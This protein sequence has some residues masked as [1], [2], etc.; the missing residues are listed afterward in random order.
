MP[1]RG[2]QPFIAR[3]AVRRGRYDPQSVP[4]SASNEPSLSRSIYLAGP[5]FTTSQRWLIAEAYRILTDFGLAVFSPFHD[6]G[7]G[8]P[9]KVVHQDLNGLDASSLVYAIVDGIDP[10]TLFEIGY[11][12]AKGIDVVALAESHSGES[13]TMLFGSQCRVYRDFAASLYECC[14]T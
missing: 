3:K 5:F 1:Q 2:Q 6:I 10:G 13:L 8:S 14:W 11:A 9:A 12:R 7:L 4:W